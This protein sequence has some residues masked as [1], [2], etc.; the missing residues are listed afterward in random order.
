VAWA[1]YFENLGAVRLFP[2]KALG[3]GLDREG[4]L[5]FLMYCLLTEIVLSRRFKSSQR[6]AYQFVFSQSAYHF[7]VEH[8]EYPAGVGCFRVGFQMFGPE[9]LHLHLLYLGSN[10][11]IGGI[12]GDGSFFYR[13]FKCAVEYEM[14]VTHRGAAQAGIAFTTLLLYPAMCLFSS[15]A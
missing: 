6:R 9:S 4:P 12:A 11:V 15:K 13:P 1:S 3:L 2:A 7:Q 8:G 5:G 10:A 14:D